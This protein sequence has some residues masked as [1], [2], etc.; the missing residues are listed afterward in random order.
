[1]QEID[2][3]FVPGHSDVPVSGRVFGPEEMINDEPG[4]L[5]WG[6]PWADI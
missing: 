2:E 5:G 4:V 3:P 1:M 6:V